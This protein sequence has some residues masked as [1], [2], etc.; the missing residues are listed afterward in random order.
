M[1][2]ITDYT[3]KAQVQTFLDYARACSSRNYLVLRV[4]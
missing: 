2:N 1:K 3:E 4:L